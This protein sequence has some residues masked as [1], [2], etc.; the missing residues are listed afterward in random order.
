MDLNT[1]HTDEGDTMFTMRPRSLRS[2]L[3]MSL[4]AVAL[5]AA[6]AKSSTPTAGGTT[7]S[8]PS[9]AAGAVKVASSDV[10]GVGTVLV[11]DS[12]FTLYHLKTETAGKIEC[13]GSCVG[14]WP[15]VLLPAGVMAAHAGSGLTGT[16]GTIH[17]PD[18]GTQ[19]TYNGF[20]L[21]TY[22]GDTAAGQ[23]NGQGIQGVWFAVT[24]AGSGGT[25]PSTSAS[26]GGGTGY[27]Y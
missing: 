20:P 2:V 12:G 5:L 16:L 24:A 1:A 18:G 22:S 27:G 3:I 9:A 19:V 7:P 15:P 13:T 23:A 4:A 17:R 14:V 25:P 26:S 6:C 11:N 10:S 21:Y 8:A